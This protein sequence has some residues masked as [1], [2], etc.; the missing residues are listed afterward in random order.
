MTSQQKEAQR[1]VWEQWDWVWHVSAYTFLGLSIVIDLGGSTPTDPLWLFLGLSTLLAIWYLP[2]I[3]APIMHWRKTTWH[4]VLYILIGWALWGGLLAL[5]DRS[6]MLAAM[7]YPMIFTRFPVR[8]AIATA[9]SQTLGI[10]LVFALLYTPDNWYVSLS[11]TFGLLA[12]AILLGVFISTLVKQSLERQR[13]LNEFSQTR[14]NLLQ[15][16]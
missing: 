16:E 8:W 5:N 14:T 11:I 13:L 1:D 9:V 3:A 12:A 10:Y 15:V 2:F 7:F 4:G 6:L